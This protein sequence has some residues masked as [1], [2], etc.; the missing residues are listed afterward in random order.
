MQPFIYKIIIPSILVFAV[1]HISYA[2]LDTD[3][4]DLEKIVVT[5]SRIDED[6][7]DTS[8]NVDIITSKDIERS[9]ATDISQVLTELTS[10]NISN[11][12]G[13][14]ATKTIMMRGSTASQ[15]LV[16]VD[17]R[18]INSPRDGQVDLSRV[19]LDN[20][21]RIEVLHGPSS[22]L[23]GSQAMG[24]VVNIITKNPPKKG[25]K[26]EVSSS[27]GTFQTYT[28][29]F[30][31]GARISHFGYI[32]SGGYQSSHG[33]RDN[34]AVDAKDLNTKFDYSI[35]ENHTLTLNSGFYREKLGTP[36]PINAVDL[37][38]K[39]VALNHFLDF[40]WHFKPEET[41]ELSS[42]IYQN[43]DRLEFM[44]NSSGSMFDTP[45]SK[46]I[47]TTKVRGIDVQLYKKLFTNY[48]GICGFNYVKNINDST[49]AAK[50]EYIVRA[51]YIDNKLN[52]FEKLKIDF[53]IRIDDYSN[54]GT[55]A[56][57]SLSALYNLHDNIR[58]H[59]LISRS[60]R[61][62]TFNDLYWPDQG[63]AKGN[64]ELKPETGITFETGVNTD[65][66]DAINSSLT[67]YHNKF[68]ELI[69]WTEVS[70][71]WQP[72]N[73][74]SAVIDG[75]EF[76]NKVKILD[77]FEFDAGYT[78]LMARDEKTHKYLIYQPKHKADFSL[79]YKEINGFAC[80]LKGEF[81]GQR[82]HDAEDT[83]KVKRFFVLGFNIS[84]KFKSGITC[85]GSIDNVLGRKYQVIRGYP[86]P[87][88][89]M[90]GG[91]KFE[92]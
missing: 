29:R 61:A 18:P 74:G 27:Y 90:T 4:V 7:N 47:Q 17:G 31:Q 38:D 77:N 35:G 43:Y 88:F 52:L 84:K 34:T 2:G 49:N 92:I 25:Q 41:L 48:Q 1:C 54:F 57:P 53:G 73:I 78:F 63:W 87:G 10:V 64:P 30:S 85:F 71:V 51:G 23:Y 15:V 58:L 80:Q 32:V 46:D 37:D 83:I 86:M 6:C 19:P 60:F 55:Q 65:I 45:F 66:N 67:Y 76:E 12:G 26:T 16:M 70:G 40:G 82:F 72:K 56:N 91:V 79:T 33:F 13:L 28:D 69:N 21:N 62:P 44:E 11:Y 68:D 14:G 81:T 24:G 59:G 36:G 42:K 8:R 22:S 39:Q 75:V 5:P 50:H 9:Q 3:D 20:I 89:S